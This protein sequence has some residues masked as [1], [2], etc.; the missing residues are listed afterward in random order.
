MVKARMQ[1]YPVSIDVTRKAVE[2]HHSPEGP[3]LSASQETAQ[4]YLLMEQ[5]SL[6]GIY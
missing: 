6:M 5:E 2:A 4:T 3:K 1:T